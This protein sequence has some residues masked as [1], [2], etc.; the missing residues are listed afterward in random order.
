V[1]GHLVVVRLR[2]AD[3]HALAYGLDPFRAQVGGSDPDE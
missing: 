1:G 3:A 2:E